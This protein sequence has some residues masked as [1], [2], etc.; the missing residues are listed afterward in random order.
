MAEH[1]NNHHAESSNIPANKMS[2][3]INTIEYF[4]GKSKRF[5]KKFTNKKRRQ[6]LKQNKEDKI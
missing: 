6:L 3:D 4:K 1:L 2:G 5:F